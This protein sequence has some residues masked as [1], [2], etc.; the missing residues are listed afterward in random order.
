[1]RDILTIV[2]HKKQVVLYQPRCLKCGFITKSSTD[3]NTV[4]QLMQEHLM[5]SHHIPFQPLVYED[6]DKHGNPV[7]KRVPLSDFS[8][9]FNIVRW[10]NSV[11]IRKVLEDEK[12]PQFY[13][14]AGCRPK[15]CK[16][17][18]IA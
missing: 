3:T 2:K 13:A 14:V 6:E 7:I 1:M 17:K 11:D 9:L 15:D 12:Q 18:V 4:K 10:T 8:E 5:K 16:A